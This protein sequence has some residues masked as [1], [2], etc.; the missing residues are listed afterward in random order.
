MHK[1]RSLTI[2]ASNETPRLMR[3]F[4]FRRSE[5]VHEDQSKLLQATGQRGGE[6]H[7]ARQLHQGDRVLSVLQ[8]TAL[9]TTEST[10]AD[11][12]HVRNQ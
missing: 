9:Q 4:C 1:I 10:E 3:I 5:R 12:K 8:A 6:R 7:G 2:V 11:E